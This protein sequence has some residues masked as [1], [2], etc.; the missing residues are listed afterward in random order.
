MGADRK[1]KW[2]DGVPDAV[3]VVG[4]R[5]AACLLNLVGSDRN[6]SDRLC[7]VVHLYC[8]MQLL[9]V[10]TA[11]AVRLQSHSELDHNNTELTEL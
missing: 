5:Q 7:Y 1:Q 3:S 4:A 8:K 2:P 9:L 6:N 11:L 10:S